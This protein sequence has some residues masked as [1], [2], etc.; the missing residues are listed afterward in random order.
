[1]SYLDWWMAVE[2]ERQLLFWMS[3]GMIMSGFM[4][5]LV[6]L[7]IPAPYGRYS[8][9]AWGFLIDSR[10]AWFIQEV[11]SLLIPLAFWLFSDTDIMLPNKLLL[12]VFVAHYIQ[13]FVK[14]KR[15]TMNFLML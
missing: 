9:T 12:C 13:R 2:T 11:P 15:E 10:Y 8:S 1:M 4:S 5:F 7:L 14:L 3:Y 6:L